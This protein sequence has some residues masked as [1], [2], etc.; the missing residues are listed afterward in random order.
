MARTKR[1]VRHCLSARHEKRLKARGL[2]ATD[3]IQIANLYKCTMEELLAMYKCRK[4]M[5]QHPVA[6]AKLWL[7]RNQSGPEDR[8]KALV[9]FDISAYLETW[10]PYAGCLQGD[11][12]LVMDKQGRTY[13]ILAERCHKIERLHPNG[14]KYPETKING[15]MLTPSAMIEHGDH[16]ITKGSRV[17][18]LESNSC[19]VQGTG[20]G[21]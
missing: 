4:S 10:V 2:T 3:A 1:V 13:R 15:L 8:R 9:Y 19:A 12:V 21:L 14:Y 7:K 20:Y 6:K 11:V 16:V 18:V 5:I 17:S